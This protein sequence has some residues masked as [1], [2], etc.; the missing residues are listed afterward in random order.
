MHLEGQGHSL[1]NYLAQK[2]SVPELGRLFLSQVFCLKIV[3]GEED[4]SAS[5]GFLHKQTW[6]I[7]TE[8]LN[9]PARLQCQ[10]W[11][12]ESRESQGLTV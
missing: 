6:V 4:G 9:V 10:H 2:Q 7:A 12:A 8:N 5:K 3:W 11:G 1:S